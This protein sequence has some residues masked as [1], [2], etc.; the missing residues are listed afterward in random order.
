MPGPPPTPNVIKLL[1]GNP[2]RRPIRAE[3]QPTQTPEPPDAP[4]YLTGYAADE[5]YRIAPEL[6]RLGLLT[7]LDVHM[8]ALYCEAYKTWRAAL[9]AVAKVAE[10]DQTTSGLLIRG[11]DGTPRQNP[12]MRTAGDML[13]YAGEFG[14][15]AVART[16]LAGAGFEPPT[17]GKFD[18]LLA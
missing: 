18:G 3:P 5:W 1:R 11:V 6:H 17:G 4:V 9:E 16:G 12:L 8:L 13:R 15:T 10:R 14:L 7:V 2:G